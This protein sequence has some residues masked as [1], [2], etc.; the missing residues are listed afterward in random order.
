MVPESFGLTGPHVNQVVAL[1]HLTYQVSG[2]SILNKVALLTIFALLVVSRALCH[3]L[4]GSDTNC[5][6]LLTRSQQLRETAIVVA[7]LWGVGATTK[8]LGAS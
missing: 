3:T 8:F 5:R 6:S 1:R 4:P 7:V 2:C